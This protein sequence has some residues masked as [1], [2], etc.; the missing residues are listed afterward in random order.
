MK[1][2]PQQPSHN[3]KPQIE[4][5]TSRLSIW[6]ASVLSLLLTTAA[7]QADGSFSTA[8]PIEPGET[9]AAI[10]AVNEMDYFKFTI[11]S[12]QMVTL[13]CKAAAV[14][15]V[16][17]KLQIKLYDAAWNSITYNGF[18]QSPSVN[19][20]LQPGTYYVQVSAWTNTT[21]PYRLVLKSQSSATPLTEVTQGNFDVSNDWETYKFTVINP[22][23]VLLRAR[24]PA[25]ATP[26]IKL[27]MVV[28]DEVGNRLDTSSGSDAGF[29]DILSP[30]NYFVTIYS[31]FSGDFNLKF[32]TPDQAIALPEG[33]TSGL[34]DLP[35]D[36]DYYKFS[37]PGTTPKSIR[38]QTSG[39][40]FLNLRLRNQFGEVL[41]SYGVPKL[42]GH[43]HE[44]TLDPGNYFLSVYG[45]A[46]S[47]VGATGSYD[48][49]LSGITPAVP[50]IM[51]QQP[52]G[53]NL[54]DGISR[55]AFGTT[56]AKI[57]TGIT[58][59]FVIRN[60]GSASLTGIKLSKSGKNQND[61]QV[62][63]TPA[64]TI[65]PGAQTTFTVT[66]RPKTVGMKRASL[67]II[68][69]DSD[70]SPFDIPVSGLSVK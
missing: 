24:R 52:A 51:V 40:A 60:T 21:G 65:A 22:G 56:K 18:N 11:T 27:T 28:R 9:A 59:T 43:D 10:S 47:G 15:I 63:T 33:T 25:L 16:P 30:G 35:R 36:Y 55:R 4:A 48:L 53:S 38:L 17:T 31:G 44:V 50:E 5:G 57:K 41:A 45:D 7:L 54:M 8:V 23:F 39:T 12:P 29:G 64:A 2:D 14:G 66:F 49:T 20:F 61:F 13:A 3:P 67:R 26:A 46:E 37:I 42:P 1:S 68:S 19:W 32:V 69:N 34:I 58:K 70:E 6:K 62:R